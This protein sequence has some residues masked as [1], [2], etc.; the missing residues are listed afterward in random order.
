[1][2]AYPQQTPLTAVND[3][4]A[5]VFVIMQLIAKLAGPTLVSVVDCSNSGAVAQA[6]TVNV[7][8]LV[9]QLTGNQQPQPHG[10]IYNLPY[11]RLASGNSAFIVDPSPNDIGLACF[12]SRDISAVKSFAQANPGVAIGTQNPSSLRSWDWADG[13]YLLSIFG[14]VP[15][16]YIQVNAQGINIVSP[17]QITLTAPTISLNASSGINLNSAAVDPNGIITDGAGIVSN[18]H[19]HSGVQ[20]GSSDSGGPV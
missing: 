15:T 13:I 5:Q 17:Q 6:G 1:M 2:M 9:N 18:T 12:C 14:G 16:Q 3:Y 11:L 10:E 7:Q 4:L 20:T 19:L 8:P